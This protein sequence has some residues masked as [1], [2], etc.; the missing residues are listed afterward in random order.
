MIRELVGQGVA[1]AVAAM[2]AGALL[3]GDAPAAGATDA[4]CER[5]VLERLYFGLSTPWGEAS[6]DDWQRFVDRELAPRFPAGFTVLHARGHW[7]DATQSPLHEPSRVVDLVHARDPLAAA[8]IA[9]VVARYRQQFAQQSVLR[10][11]T[12]V[13][14]CD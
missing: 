6:D 1:A 14:A 8:R 12:E 4:Q 10:L 11:S 2:A 13:Q 9:E 3:T 7:R 5:R